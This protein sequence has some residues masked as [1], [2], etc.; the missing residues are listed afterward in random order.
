[1]TNLVP[2]GHWLK[3]KREKR[4]N[5]ARPNHFYVAPVRIRVFK[6]LMCRRLR[7]PPPPACKIFEIINNKFTEMLEVP[8]FFC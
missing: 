3:E 2:L 5:V 1:M 6:K 7:S 4:S 8:Y